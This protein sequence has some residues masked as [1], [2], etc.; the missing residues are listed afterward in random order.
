[1]DRV[2]KMC[3]LHTCTQGTRVRKE[4]L[5]CTY[6]H[7][8]SQREVLTVY[9]HE[10]KLRSKYQLHTHL[11]SEPKRSMCLLRPGTDKVRNSVHPP[12]AK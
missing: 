4:H 6:T 11:K 5:L 10:Q 1:M 3:L 8:Q 9:T 7:E 2:R 12:L